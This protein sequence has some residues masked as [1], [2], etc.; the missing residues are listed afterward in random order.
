MGLKINILVTVS[1]EHFSEGAIRR[2]AYLAKRFEGEL[3]L[4]YIIEE[5]VLRMIDRTAEYI[6]TTEE[7]ERTEEELLKEIRG[8][9]KEMLFERAALLAT[10][11]GAAISQWEIKQGEYGQVILDYCKRRRIDLVVMSFTRATLLRYAILDW[12]SPPIWVEKDGLNL[13]A[14]MEVKRILA[15]PSSLSPNR[16]LLGIALEFARRLGAELYMEYVL[17]PATGDGDGDGALR[18]GEE[19]LRRCE[20]E[21]RPKLPELT[22][23]LL[24][25]RLERVALTRARELQADLLILGEELEPPLKGWLFRRE[26]RQR[27]L[28]G[29]P[30]SLLFVK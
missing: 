14:E 3:T 22:C 24:R 2:A 13:K 28:A 20:R 15:L 11:E 18:E 23:A 8:R 10:R 5:T 21:L 9:A 29:S 7:L 4:L 17:D 30:C 19:F 25:G 12:D 6:M 1:S 16:K 26:I 27:V